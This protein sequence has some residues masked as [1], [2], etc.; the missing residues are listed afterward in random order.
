MSRQ[1]DCRFSAGI[2]ALVLVLVVAAAPAL[3][4]VYTGR[5]ISFE[6]GNDGFTR[7]SFRADLESC[8]CVYLQPSQTTNFTTSQSSMLEVSCPA[9][10]DNLRWGNTSLEKC[11]ADTNECDFTQSW[12]FVGN[13]ADDLAQRMFDGIKDNY[14]AVLNSCPRRVARLGNGEG[15]DRPVE[16]APVITGFVLTLTFGYL[17]F[18]VVLFASFC[19]V[20]RVMVGKA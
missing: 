19:I 12:Y 5:S 13:G 8:V 15:L 14:T 16:T 7:D 9:S 1:L 3:A 18:S 20:Q 4:S 2:V 10:R 17:A 6:N 11:S